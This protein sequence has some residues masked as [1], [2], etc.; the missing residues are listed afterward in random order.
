[1]E[2]NIFWG[3]SIFVYVEDPKNRFREL[4]EINTDLKSVPN[5][6]SKFKEII[7]KLLMDVEGFRTV[8]TE[9]I[10]GRYRIKTYIEFPRPL[11]LTDNKTPGEVKKDIVEITIPE[12]EKCC[13]DALEQDTVN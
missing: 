4:A 5:D 10:G 8:T 2:N 3:K 1:M 9:F 6:E 13:K 7:K 11:I 12:I